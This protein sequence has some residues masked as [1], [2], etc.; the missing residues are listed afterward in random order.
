MR[1]KVVGF[2]EE[3]RRQREASSQVFRTTI[4]G[5]FSKQIK[6]LAATN[7]MEVLPRLPD[8]PASAIQ[9]LRYRLGCAAPCPLALQTTPAPKVKSSTPTL[10]RP[11]SRKPCIPSVNCPGAEHVRGGTWSVVIPHR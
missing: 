2:R 5:G 3:I 10:R 9:V 7:M 1:S 4:Q 11:H 8:N 6:M